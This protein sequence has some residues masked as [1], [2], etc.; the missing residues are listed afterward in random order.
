MSS[1][2]E[3]LLA[4]MGVASG[5]VPPQ[6]P[7]AC[8]G[9][10]IVYSD[11]VAK[12]STTAA[13]LQTKCHAFWDALVRFLTYDWS[14]D[15]RA[16]VSNTFRRV[17]LGCQGCN[18]SRRTLEQCG[19]TSAVFDV[20]F[21]ALSS[22]LAAA[23]IP[24]PFDSK[25]GRWP[26]TPEQLF[27]GGPQ[28]TMGA[29]LA[30]LESGGPAEIVILKLVHD[31]RPLA[32]PV[33]LTSE[34]RAR[35]IKT[36]VSRVSRTVAA[37]DAD[38]AKLRQPVLPA[39]RDAIARRHIKPCLPSVLMLSMFAFG[40][41]TKQLDKV[42]LFYQREH[43]LFAP[44]H[45]V[46]SQ[47]EQPE[48]THEHLTHFTGYLWHAMSSPHRGEVG[49]PEVPTYAIGMQEEQDATM[50][51][52]YHAL[53]HYL[54]LQ[55]GRGDWFASSHMTGVLTCVPLSRTHFDACTWV[56]RGAT[57]P[58]ELWSSAESPALPS[59]SCSMLCH[60]VWLRLSTF[61]EPSV[62]AASLGAGRRRPSSSS[63]ADRSARWAH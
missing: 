62:S 63:L 29:L 43:E 41:E 12:D 39:V 36:I 17:H 13:L 49:C 15:Q 50:R 18:P 56:V 54:L 23:L 40:P 28:R 35:L 24:E 46:A 25:L 58:D 38:I 37:I 6:T 47:F 31:A 30:L 60:P 3:L 21:H 5:L 45:Q 19:I 42:L 52:P 59:M 34:N 11:Q 16:S 53:Q 55:A 14:R 22:C 2:K 33:L 27:P 1:E 48:K 7:V 26:T 20:V 9:C 32:F 61:H 4:A 10:V 57:R 8:P 51:D 44:L